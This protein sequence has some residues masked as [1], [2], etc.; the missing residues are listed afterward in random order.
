MT[1]KQ[2]SGAGFISMVQGSTKS[3]V[4]MWWT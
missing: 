1:V 3:C 4:E 2:N